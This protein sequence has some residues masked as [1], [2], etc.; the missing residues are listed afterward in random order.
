MEAGAIIGNPQLALWHS[1][2][3]Q[4]PDDPASNEGRPGWMYGVR[5]YG[6]HTYLRFLTEVMGV[7]RSFMTD[8]F[9]ASTE[10]SPKEYIYSLVGSETMRS[11]F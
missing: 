6:M 8:R 5:Q 9:Y 4:A 7:E 3:N 1:F 10:M 11:H 2:G